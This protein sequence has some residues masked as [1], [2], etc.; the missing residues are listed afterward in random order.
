MQQSGIQFLPGKI[1]TSK[2]ERRL[3]Q[4]TKQQLS[5]LLTSPE[6]LDWQKQQQHDVQN[7]SA[8]SRTFSRRACIALLSFLLLVPALLAPHYISSV[9]QVSFLSMKQYIQQFPAVPFH[10]VCPV[11][12]EAC[13]CLGRCPLQPGNSNQLATWTVL[14]SR[15]SST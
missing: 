13:S 12:H 1:S 3:D 2:Y 4:C 11:E 10:A 15:M 8:S 5:L 7:S 14:S 6:Y 9:K